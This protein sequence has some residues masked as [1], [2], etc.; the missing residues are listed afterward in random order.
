MAEG[1]VGKVVSI[2]ALIGVGLFVLSSIYGAQPTSSTYELDNETHSMDPPPENWSALKSS[3]ITQAATNLNVANVYNKSEVA[4]P[5]DHYNVNSSAPNYALNLTS[6]WNYTGADG[7]QANVTYSFDN[8]PG[9]ARKAAEHT[10]SAFKLAA[11]VPLVLFAVVI[12][13]KIVDLRG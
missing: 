4:V 1:V 9:M 8:K 6:E 7:S 12:L 10:G 13:A 2:A 3:D 5:S 11:I